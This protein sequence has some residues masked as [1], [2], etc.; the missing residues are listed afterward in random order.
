MAGQGP[1]SGEE[2]GP[3]LGVHEKPVQLTPLMV[4]A[5][6][7][8]NMGFPDQLK[9]PHVVVVFVQLPPGCTEVS[10]L[11]AVPLV[12]TPMLGKFAPM[13]IRRRKRRHRVHVGYDRACGTHHG[14]PIAADVPCHAYARVKIPVIAI[15]HA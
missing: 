14:L 2:N 11:I 7:P 5:A 9:R 1:N 15:V 3:V 6:L 4:A 8:G 10:A 12:L 13:R